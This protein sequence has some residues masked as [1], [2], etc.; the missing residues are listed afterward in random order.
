MKLVT[1]ATIRKNLRQHGNYVPDTDT[2]YEFLVN[3]GFKPKKHTYL[4]KTA[5]A[6]NAESEVGRNLYRLKQID[7]DKKR[8]QQWVKDNTAEPID[9]PNYVPRRH[10]E[11][12]ASLELLRNDEAVGKRALLEYYYGN[13]DNIS[14]DGYSLRWTSED[15][16]TFGYFPVTLDNKYKFFSS[17]QNE[18]MMTSHYD[19]ACK[20]AYELIKGRKNSFNPNEFNHIIGCVLDKGVLLGRCWMNAGVISFWTPFEIDDRD[21]SNSN[22]K[23]SDLVKVLN[24]L[25]IS[26]NEYSDWTLVTVET[27]YGVTDYV[28]DP[29]TTLAHSKLEMYDPSYKI[30]A[31]WELKDRIWDKIE[32]IV[33][34][35][36]SEDAESSKRQQIDS[37][38]GN[39]TYAQYRSML[40]QEGEKPSLTVL[41]LDD[42]REPYR[43][44]SSKS[45]SN[46]FARNKQFYDTLS[47]K[48]DINFVW[49]KNMYQFIE[50]IEKNGVPQ[51]V[52]F[53]HDL[54]NRGGG[55]GLSDEQ[56][57]NNNGVNCAKW[58]VEFC[59]KNKIN[60]PKFYVHSAN[61]KHGP[62]INKVLTSSYMVEEKNGNERR[63]I[64]INESQLRR[65]LE[66]TVDDGFR[67][68]FN[69]ENGQVNQNDPN[70]VMFDPNVDYYAD[71]KIFKDGSK[72]FN[73]YYQDLPKSGL[74][75]INLYFIRNMNIN[76]ALKHGKNV[77]GNK[78]NTYS[79]YA[80]NSLEY[81]KK[82]SAYYITR[83]LNKMGVMPDV[84][85]SPQSSSKFNEDMLNLLS[86]Y[87]P[88]GDVFVMPS[89]LRKD[90]RN[91]YVDINVAK[92]IGM[93]DD[94]IAKL[95]NKVDNMKKDEDIRD[96]RRKIEQL[97]KEIEELYAQ[98]E[99]R[100]GRPSKKE[101]SDIWDR[102]D[103]IDAYNTLIKANRRRGRD[104]TIDS[105]TGQIKPMQIKSMDDMQRRAIDG[106][107]VFNDIDYPSRTYSVGGDNYTYSQSMRLRNKVVLVF[108]DNLSSG[109]TLDMMC[110]ALLKMGVKKVIPITLGLI[111]QTAYNPS[112]RAKLRH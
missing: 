5:F 20:A 63:K 10:G 54:N 41:W 33:S 104:S 25:G 100:R 67:M 29:E 42:Q 4:V 69:K 61:P 16:V 28:Y 83:I 50:Y 76:K 65:L 57:L 87:Y 47:Q 64:Y 39:M 97:K 79:Q 102:R 36:S 89:S 55:E 6:S 91:V 56:K 88:N 43:Y 17:S 37:K 51:F 62:E 101:M 81:F 21:Y 35:S 24:D 18:A 46:T 40:Y 2:I 80:A 9:R 13:P 94:D 109:A 75:S 48:Y 111:P 108:D 95:Q 3:K 92:Q 49:V 72:E 66:N 70:M 84:F 90:P 45:A 110:A 58:L 52:S 86:K 105:K 59:R 106:L 60:L 44:L 74:K 93:S 1:I 103:E 53:D 78:V 23:P 30:N 14:C 98:R 112:E 8:A 7:D 34:P 38:L 82:R 73:I 11:S 12:N 27:G 32:A 31:V 77:S 107:F 71:T 85:T 68:S 26:E 96:F 99:H 15:A 22:V 19:L